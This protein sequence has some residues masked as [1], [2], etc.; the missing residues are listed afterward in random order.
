[1]I[2]DNIFGG[3]RF[4][5]TQAL[6]GGTYIMLSLG[7]LLVAVAALVTAVRCTRRRLSTV[8]AWLLLVACA[9]SFLLGAGM[10]AYY[11]FYQ[12]FWEALGEQGIFAVDVLFFVLDCLFT[13]AIGAALVLFRPAHEA[14]VPAS[15]EVSHG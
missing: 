5:D 15:G 7:E 4:M 13:M 11:F 14:V 8:A 9:A 2:G 6:W 3:V 10:R 1:M 12:T